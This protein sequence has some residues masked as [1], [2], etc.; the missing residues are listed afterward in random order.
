MFGK[1]GPRKKISPAPPRRAQ[2]NVRSSRSATGA[3]LALARRAGRVRGKAAEAVADLGMAAHLALFLL[4]QRPRLQE[5]EVI[6][7]DLTDVVDACRVADQLD[8]RV[9]QAKTSCESLRERR[10]PLGVAVR[11]RVT[12]IDQVGELEDR[13]LRLFPYARAIAEREQDNRHRHAE[14]EERPRR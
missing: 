10:D 11:V 3:K 5:D 4:R 12:Q 14:E 9:L 6:R 1:N 7:S 13:G 2:L 8:L